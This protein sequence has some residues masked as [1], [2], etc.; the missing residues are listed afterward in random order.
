MAGQEALE[1]GKGV[2][3]EVAWGAEGRT[4]QK[5][6]EVLVV[7][8]NFK[9]HRCLGWPS[10]TE[11]RGCGGRGGHLLYAICCIS[12]LYARVVPHVGVVLCARVRAAG[13]AAL[14]E[15]EG[16]ARAEGGAPEGDHCIRA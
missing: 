15:R 1:G 16:S 11:R 10:Q 3:G 2:G 4:H 14:L 7:V 5:N 12:R 8:C 9:V 6:T 13:G